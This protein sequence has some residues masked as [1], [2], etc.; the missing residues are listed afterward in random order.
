M[1]TALCTCMRAHPPRAAAATAATALH[2][3]SQPH[4]PAGSGKTRIAE[5]LIHHLLPALRAS[6]RNVVFLA[7]NIPLVQQVRWRHPHGP[8]HTHTRWPPSPPLHLHIL[9]YILLPM[10]LI[11][12]PSH[13]RP[14][15]PCT[16]T[17]HLLWPHFALAPPNTRLPPPDLHTR[18][19]T[20]THAPRPHIS[21][22]SHTHASLSPHAGCLL[23][24]PHGVLVMLPACLGGGH[25]MWW[26]GAGSRI[27]SQP[28][29]LAPGGGPR[30]PPATEPWG[31]F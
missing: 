30:R 29:A 28:L 15:S 18:A 24:A 3:L 5:D 17:P 23:G 1:M 19:D 9:A 4:T 21:I 31:T 7:P 10:H 11:P 22:P 6:N 25:V 27:F 12:P 16:S 20:L 8:P 2:A 26:C 14:P 13:A